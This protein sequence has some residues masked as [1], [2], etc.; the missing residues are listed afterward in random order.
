MNRKVIGITLLLVVLPFTATF[1]QN[2][3]AGQI[4]YCVQEDQTGEM[5]WG[6]V[7][8]I[9][10]SQIPVVNTITTK[11][12][13]SMLFSSKE[14]LGQSEL[15]VL[16]FFTVKQFQLTPAFYIGIGGGMWH[17]ITEG[18]DSEHFAVRAE[19]GFKLGK[20]AGSLMELYVGTDIVR[21]T[22]PD[23]FYPHVSLSIF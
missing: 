8:D 12:E 5:A 14:W 10:T 15:N 11:I 2:V 21:V 19:T 20:V 22:G 16:R 17:T 13:G 4:G 3:V 7:T 23:L 6:F 1:S 18:D 9:S